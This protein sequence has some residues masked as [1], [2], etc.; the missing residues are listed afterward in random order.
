LSELDLSNNKLE[1]DFPTQV[2]EAPLEI[3]DLRFNAFTGEIPEILFKND[4]LLTFLNNNQ[5]TGELPEFGAVQLTYFTVAN[6]GLTGPI[7]ESIA[8]ITD[9]KELVFSGNN[10]TGTIP[11][12]LCALDLDVLDFTDNPE[13]DTTLGPNCKALLDAGILVI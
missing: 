4:M 3:L 6:N 12:D 8:D 10:F 13:L 11:E 9:A 1:G 7:P 5:F 2:L